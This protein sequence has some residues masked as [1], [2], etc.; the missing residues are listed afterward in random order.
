[1]A[2][3]E[4]DYYEVLGVSRGASDAEIK[5][6]FRA[7]AR[8]LH[9]DVSADPD[10]D[11]RF[12]EV[13]EA[14]EVLSDPDRRATYDRY[15]HAGL[16]RGGYHPT[17]ADFGSIADVFAAFFGDD[18]YGMSGAATRQSTRGGDVLAVV[19]IDLEEAFTGV[20]TAVSVEV[21]IP[22]SRC[23]S[24]GAEPGTGTTTC[25]VCAGAGVLRRVSRSVFGEFVSQRTCSECGGVGRV[26]EQPCSECAGEGRLLETRTL[27]V[28]IPAGIQD[29]QRIR[30]RGQGHAGFQGASPGDA[31][32]A[33]RV[34]PDPR[35]V[36]DGEDLH[37]AVRLTMTD[38][39]LGT[40]ILVPGV[41]GELELEIPAGTQPGEA[42]VLRGQ[43][44]PS[45]NG[46]RRGDLYVRLD[47]VVPR[48]L[49]AEQRK[50]LEELDREVGEDAY[51]A[52]D[53]EDE[54]F[55]RRLKSA[56]R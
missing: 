5:R 24:S 2:T 16:R 38:A 54:G 29:G 13:A 53:D 36:R 23:G 51:V 7:L 22:C 14:Y 6:A 41:G 49:S 9:P 30:V 10:A 56:L 8:E 4:R 15:G 19:D 27:D 50:A 46:S 21:A 48:K 52:S 44:M 34:R 35:F 26:L 47:V 11:G 42:R 40:T 33:V 32:V 25:S 1:M 3:T 55:F 28:E 45:L 43:G 17:F 18:P 39:A 12:R 20:S 37:T 31:F